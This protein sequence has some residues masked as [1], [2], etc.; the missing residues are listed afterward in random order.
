[1]KLLTVAAAAT[2]LGWDHTFE[3]TVRAT[4]PLGSDGI[5]RGDLVVRGGGDPTIGNRSTSGGSVSTLADALWQRGV[6]RVEGRVVGDASAFARE[7]LGEG[8]AWDDL[9]FSY[10]APAGALIY[11]E[12]DAQITVAPGASAGDCR[13]GGA[14][15]RGLRP[16]RAVVCRHGR[17][18]KLHRRRR[19]AR[20]GVG[21]GRGARDDR[22]RSRPGDSLRGGQRREP[23]L[24]VG[25]AIGARRT[26]DRRA[27]SSG[28][29]RRLSSGAALSARRRSSRR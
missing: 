14:R 8:W 29:R 27:R 22:G 10:S 4:T 17:P 7:P 21:R 12:N 18:G 24:R 11:N 19:L 25:T 13:R 28:E 26:R 5:V 1:M 6:R 20:P 3:T 15:R 9:P 2:R 16:A 23:L